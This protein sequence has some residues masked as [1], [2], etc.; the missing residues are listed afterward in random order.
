MFGEPNKG[1]HFHVFGIAIVDV[2]MTLLAALV[3][4]KLFSIKFV[5]TTI[6]MFLLGI[7]AH[8]VF[9]V[10]TTIDKLLF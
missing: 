8:R 5:Y 4:S 6:G 2:C 9:R 10:H 3:L 7:I 1:I